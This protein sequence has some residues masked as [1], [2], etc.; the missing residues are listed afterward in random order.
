MVTYKTQFV[1]LGAT[2]KS[3][4]LLPGD[5]RRHVL[6]FS[7][8]GYASNVFF[9]DFPFDT[10]VNQNQA[11][12]LFRPSGEQSIMLYRDWGPIMQSSLYITA[13]PQQD[14]RITEI[15]IQ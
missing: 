12:V 15:L 4:F 2:T 13:S 10:S 11:F 14:F 9:S 6:I 5:S 3:D 1:N 8:G 7:T